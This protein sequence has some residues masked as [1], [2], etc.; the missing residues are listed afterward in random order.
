[1]NPVPLLAALLAVPS[2]AALACSIPEDKRPVEVQRDEFARDSY[3]R[4]RALVEVIAVESSHRRRP[5]VVRVVR[6]LEGPLRR[7]R[8]LT[9]HSVDPSLCGAGDFRRGSSGLILLDRLGAPLDFHGY[10]PTDY[11]QR[12]DRLGLRPIGGTAERR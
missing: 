1:M 10:L 8:L 9:L 5:G 12:L 4:A 2:G 3:S 11:L 6:V 7:G